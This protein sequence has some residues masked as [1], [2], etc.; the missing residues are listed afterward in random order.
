MSTF[1]IT[2]PQCGAALEA[3]EKYLGFLVA[4]ADCDH[5]FTLWTPENNLPHYPD[6]LEQF[7]PG[8]LAKVGLLLSFHSPLFTEEQLALLLS[9][10]DTKRIFHFSF[11]LLR[12]LEE[13]TEINGNRRYWSES[14]E[15]FGKK[16]LI[17]KEWF[18]Y[19]R[20]LIISWLRQMEVDYTDLYDECKRYENTN[21]IGNELRSSEQCVK[22]FAAINISKGN[23]YKAGPSMHK[24]ILCLTLIWCLEK[25][26][27]TQNVFDKKILAPVF[28]QIWSILLPG[29]PVGNI[30]VPFEYL[31]SDGFWQLEKNGI[32]HFTSMMF[33][34]LSEKENRVKAT[35]QVLKSFFPD[36]NL[37][38]E[39]LWTGNIQK[40]RTPEQITEEIQINKDS[41]QDIHPNAASVAYCPNTSIRELELCPNEIRAL[42]S[43]QIKTIRDLL[44]LNLQKYSTRIGIG[45]K[46]V[47]WMKKEIER[48]K[49]IL[50]GQDSDA[51]SSAKP[52][53]VGSPHFS[54]SS[55][56]AELM[57]TKPFAF[58]I[59]EKEYQV[60]AWKHILLSVV[61][62]MRDTQV[63]T[64]LHLRNKACFKS[65]RRICFKS[66]SA[67]FIRGEKLAN[68][69]WVETNFSALDCMRVAIEFATIGKLNLDD[70]VV[71]YNGV[72]DH[73]LPEPEVD[74][75]APEKD[76][77]E[78]VPEEPQDVVPVDIPRYR[79]K[80]DWSAFTLG[81]TIP[82]KNHSAFLQ[83]L[84]VDL[85][86]GMSH[87]VKMIAKNQTFQIRINNIEFTEKDH[88]PCILFLYS[89]NTPFAR[90]MQMTFPQAY[91]QMAE[92]HSNRS[93]IDDVL[94]I[95]CGAAVDEF[96]ITF[97]REMV[98]PDNLE[99]PTPR[100][101][102]SKDDSQELQQNPVP[103][104]ISDEDKNKSSILLADYFPRGFRV[105]SS[106]ENR[107]FQA[108]W[109][110]KFESDCLLTDDD[111]QCA[112]NAVGVKF[113]DRI[114]SPAVLATDETFEEILGYVNSIFT[115]GKRFVYYE[116][117]FDEF[118][119][120]GV[121][122]KINTADMLKAFL[123][124][125]DLPYS[126]RT[127]CIAADE[128]V[129]VS[130]ID[131]IRSFMQEQLEPVGYEKM[132]QMLPHIPLEIIKRE[133]AY[134]SEFVNSGRG[135]YIHADIVD[136]S[137]REL[138]NVAE[139]I[140][141]EINSK[142]YITGTELWTK[143]E[144]EYP[145]YTNRYGHLPL[146][147]V[148]DALK[149][150]LS[151]RFNFQ[152]NVISSVDAPIEMVDVFIEFSRCRGD[153]SLEELNN[154][155]SELGISQITQQYLK[156]ICENS[157]RISETEFVA[158]ENTTFDIAGTDRAISR[159][160]P[161]DFIPIS[162]V[163]AF[164]T[165]P[166]TNYQWTSYLLE[167]YVAKCSKEFQLIHNQYNMTVCAG[168]IVRKNTGIVDYNQI[169]A[170][171]LFENDIE[172]V[173]ST[174]L[175]YLCKAGFL[176]RRRYTDMSIVLSE[177]RQL[178]SRKRGQ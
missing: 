105:A 59:G 37:T 33:S 9:E 82:I 160:C 62:Y 64:L 150:K 151:G 106:I 27:I 118:S 42:E 164:V 63:D 94:D 154:F 77:P 127:S 104:N 91:E 85:L 48:L 102:R 84:S 169:L 158:L 170:R 78:F 133:L 109:K 142:K 172:L 81:L 108:F 40:D 75:T 156:A 110:D 155:A 122:W 58:F 86:P 99:E 100:K 130:P 147:G 72:G 23:Q 38:A 153:F 145:E 138:Q 163:T 178:R 41:V 162:D 4:C 92:K 116:S 3:E 128:D 26:I 73:V 16:Y 21:P 125:K 112:M 55:P 69:L 71:Y 141:I 20:K 2:C 83:H 7:K 70:L 177:A 47:E 139:E 96:I 134:N 14:V 161:G 10:E 6:E 90:M 31:A 144:Q 32:G 19:N 29:I 80:L 143:L 121:E 146:I 152:G 45:A 137:E 76:S 171:V 74:R 39:D 89:K 107:R 35:E 140:N 132:Q 53:Y 51:N 95:A 25:A 174:A 129:S 36:K 65:T 97:D 113:E 34:F 50:N 66:T 173:E 13:G 17:S 167:S 15:L 148:R 57:H 68:N 61:E 166:A 175:D 157:M 88:K 135:E 22:L 115:S 120:R 111:I 165:F 79:K 149:H 52:P 114:Y 44:S 12:P 67:G 60:T 131:E 176:G 56:P 28:K 136:F 49:T 124:T 54:F 1:A 126:M 103:D 46:K 117:L 159:F 24:P 8:V 18:D 101:R 87:P 5:H 98:L 43:M 119:S 123:A 30:N 93:G 11:P 168:A